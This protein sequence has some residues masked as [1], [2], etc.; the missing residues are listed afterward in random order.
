[1]GR[2]NSTSLAGDP[3]IDCLCE[4]S[5]LRNSRCFFSSASFAFFANISSRRC[6]MVES[7]VGKCRSWPDVYGITG[8]ELVA[9]LLQKQY[10]NCLAYCGVSRTAASG[11][12]HVFGGCFQKRAKQGRS[13]HPRGD[14]CLPRARFRLKNLT[15][16]L[17]PNLPA[18]QAPVTF[19]TPETPST[20]VSLSPSLPLDTHDAHL[21]Y[22][23]SD[24]DGHDVYFRGG[25]RTSTPCR[26]SQCTTRSLGKLG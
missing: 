24:S 5:A 20:A 9:L 25:Q 17:Q 4:L 22:P 8:Q 21:S 14:P 6:A 11:S 26:S 19:A 2:V 13:D 18:S 23:G 3:L 10:R 1:M 16:Q 12:K 15:P 7:M